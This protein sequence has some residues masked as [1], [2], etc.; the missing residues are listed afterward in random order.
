MGVIV[1]AGVIAIA[2]VAAAECPPVGTLVSVQGP[3]HVQR[4]GSGDW[5][6]IGLGDTLCAGDVLR[7]GERGRIQATL[8]NQVRIRGD[9]NT[10]LRLVSPPDAPRSL[11]DLISGA[12]YFFSRQPRS[13][14]VDT[15]FVTAAV[16][17]TEFLIRVDGDR[18]DIRVINGTI[19]AR[20]DLGDLTIG[21][22]QAAVAGP[23]QAPT[24]VLVVRP[25]DAVQWALH[26]PPVLGRA[27]PA[28]AL[29]ASL[30]SAVDLANRG[31]TAEAFPLFDAIPEAERDAL[32]FAFRAEALLS[33]GRIDEA[34]ADLAQAL[35][36]DP[37]LSAAYAVRSII[38]VSRNDGDLGLELAQRAVELAPRSA[39]AKIALSYAEQARFE[40]ERARDAVL[41]AVD[42]E[43]DNALAWARLSE[44]WLMLGHRRRAVET[45]ERAGELSPDVAMVQTVRGFAALA[46]IDTRQAASAFRRAIELDPANP[47]PR[48][49][50]G[51]ARIRD[52]RLAE[53]RGEIENA[54]LLDPNTSLLRSY[55]GKAYFEERTTDPVEYVRNLFENFPNQEDRLAA[56]QLALAKELDPNDPTPYLYDALRKQS[57]NRPVEAL[58]DLEMSIALNDN[59]AVFRSRELLDQDRAARGAS[60]GRIYDD[61]GFQRLGVNEANYSLSLDPANASAHRFLSDLYV[62]EP[63]HEIAR[64]SEL[65]QAQL[66]QDININPVQPSLAVTN[67][68][69]LTSGGPARPGFNE[70]TRLFERNQ[71]RLNATGLAGN[72]DTF[73]NEVVVSGLYDRYSISAGQFHYETD[74]FRDNNGLNYDTQNIFMQ[75]AISPEFNI[76]TELRRVR[77]EFGDLQFN[78]DPELFAQ[79]GDLKSNQDIA[80][81]GARY[82]IS[83]SSNL[84]MSTIFNNLDWNLSD[85]PIDGADNRD[86][87]WGFQSEVAYVYDTSIV[88]VT[89]GMG[90]AH[91]DTDLR[92]DLPPIPRD[93]QIL[94]LDPTSDRFTTDHG[95]AFLY[96]NIPWDEKVL[97]TLGL[98][99]DSYREK[100]LKLNK[101]NPKLGLKWDVTSNVRFRLAAFRTLKAPLLASRTIQP[102]Q[103]AGFNQFF[104]DFNGTEAWR[105]GG[106]LDIKLR[107]DFYLGA[108]VS[109]RRLE[110][111]RIGLLQNSNNR[112]ISEDRDEQLYRAYAYWSPWNEWALSFELSYENFDSETGRTN[113]PTK[114]S[115]FSAPFGVRYFNKTGVFGVFKADLVNQEVNRQGNLQNEGDSNFVV[116]DAAMGY[117]FPERRGLAS[118]EVLNILNEEFKYQDESFRSSPRDPVVG[119][120]L[121][122]RTIVGRLT[123]NF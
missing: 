108:E 11:L 47:Q 71:A 62:S 86:R 13:L 17:G 69:I 80:R 89:G 52:G 111:H 32:Y 79:N 76:Q 6:P 91:V 7:I 48:L 2:G 78:F 73:G 57:E 117:R 66:L 107:N 23:S 49:G 20:N 63:R 94:L 115:T 90:Y 81:I 106:G 56:E 34:E 75:A 96:S 123:L 29:P 70:F 15:P 31:R 1:Q 113:I 30:A 77:T 14:N 109:E 64:V 9:Q 60:L 83:S 19:Q 100:D 65:L 61:L 99:F 98:S 88:D 110:N 116:L 35:A 54:V 85:V 122:E 28:G 3:V 105:Y 51:L 55:L 26:V 45:A 59:R 36:R 25:L 40:I 102:T 112:R 72:Q 24:D 44:L 21:S 8:A 53:G 5:Q 10:T 50:L 58:R 38:A 16:E 82:S 93:G 37:E 43:P 119:E 101:L 33:V 74:G 12:A 68:N 22:G 87:L 18:A 95:T 120:F 103:V 104:D 114:V 84:L 27:A 92:S 39:A 42:D 121:P 46:E 97:V 41:E 4:S 118:V 67:L